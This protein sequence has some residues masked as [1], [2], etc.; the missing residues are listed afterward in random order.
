MPLSPLPA[1]GSTVAISREAS[2]PSAKLTKDGSTMK[3]AIEVTGVR[4]LKSEWPVN[5]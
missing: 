5:L 3:A 1:T 2:I 4:A